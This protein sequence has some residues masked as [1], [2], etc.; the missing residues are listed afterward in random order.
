MGCG[1]DLSEQ[2][3]NNTIDNFRL[4][5]DRKFLQAIFT[6]V[7]AIDEFY[8]RKVAFQ[9]MPGSVPPESHPSWNNEVITEAQSGASV[10]AP[11]AVP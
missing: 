7:D 9:K 3:R 11:L 2:A 8:L 4:V 10:L 5:F 1:H 6:R